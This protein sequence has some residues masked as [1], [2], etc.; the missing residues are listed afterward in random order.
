MHAAILHIP[1]LPCLQ[2]GWPL[3]YDLF[4]HLARH[5]MPPPGGWAAALSAA[6]FPMEMDPDFDVDTATGFRPC[7]FRG[8]LTGFEYRS[9]PLTECDR[10]ELGLPG[11][12]DFSVTLAAGAAAW[13]IP[14]AW[15]A[16]SVLCHLSGGLLVDPQVGKMYSAREA[17]KRARDELSRSE[18]GTSEDC[19]EC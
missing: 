17:L 4:V 6:G 1:P 8:T 11:W 12:C 19:P 7:R 3:S 14:T 15:V 5:S 18:T 9:C 13:E 10:T 16:A 2:E